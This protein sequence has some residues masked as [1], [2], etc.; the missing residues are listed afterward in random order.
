MLNMLPAMKELDKKREALT[1]AYQKQMDAYN[2]AYKVLFDLNEACP[3]CDGAGKKLRSRACAEDDR[4]DPNDP[5]D[6][7]TCIHCGGSGRA[8][9][10]QDKGGEPM[11]DY[12]FY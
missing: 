12:K 2:A 9:K 1:I 8:R 7:E 6:W 5:N 3:H 4:P 11:G 10:E